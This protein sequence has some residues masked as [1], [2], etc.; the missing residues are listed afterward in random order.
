[1]TLIAEVF[2]KLRS[3][4]NKVRWMSTKFRL[5]GS[6]KKQPDERAQTLLKFAW[7][8]LYHI[9]W[10]LWRQLNFKKSVL[11]IWKIARLFPNTLS[12][13][14]KYSL[15]N[16][17]NLTQAIQMEVSR[18]QKYFSNFFSSFL[19]S[20]LNFEHFLKKGEP[21]CWCISENTDPEKPC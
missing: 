5:K 12:A 3:P 11:V 17:D 18:K 1:M 15:L 7:Q 19:K 10:L 2:R 20:S 13:D 21:H 4:K 6:F 16:R 8:H 14:G 9:D